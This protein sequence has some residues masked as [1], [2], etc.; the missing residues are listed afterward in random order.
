MR[1]IELGRFC[2]GMGT[3]WIGACSAGSPPPDTSGIGTGGTNT[4]SGGTLSS[5]GSSASG[6]SGGSTGGSIGSGSGGSIVVAGSSSGGSAGAPIC[7]Q[8]SVV[9]T[10][11]IPTVVLLVD[12]SSSMFETQP[13]AWPLLYDA[14][15][16]PT[17]GVVKPL[18]SKIR[19]GLATYKGSTTASTEA[20]ESCA[21]WAKVTPALDNHAAIDATYSPIEATWSPG[22]KWET[23]TGHA[24]TMAAADL[25]AYTP[26]PP[27]PKYLLL[28]TDGN[29][30]SCATL[31]PQCGQDLAIKATQD[32]FAQGIGLFVM[33]IGDIVA[34]PNAGCPSSARC[35]RDH[36]QDLANAGIGE[37]VRPTASCDP[38][39]TADGC[40]FKYESCNLNQT[41]TATYTSMAPD[42]GTP[43]Q[44]D[45]RNADA[46]TQIVSA[47][48]GLLNNVISC[49]VEMDAVVTGDPALGI[50]TV[51]GSPVGYN[52]PNGWTLDMTTKYNVTLTGTACDT[53]KGGAALDIQFPCDVMG[54]PVAEPR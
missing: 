7:Q 27:G 47:L 32:A 29:P 44:V 8:L 53:F 3:L 20:N 19:F 12:N 38:D 51:G 14:L 18:E 21:T 24:I 22:T 6:G 52:D 37:G 30:N 43:F 33:G 17:T 35:G 49:T 39:A 45:T 54:N 50:V 48:T 31:D 41:L 36:L 16:N 1:T 4:S 11:Q 46:T 13:P 42:V 2:L 10:P 15:M 34:Q 26:D 40:Q 5:G 25:V 9:P 28:V 23:P